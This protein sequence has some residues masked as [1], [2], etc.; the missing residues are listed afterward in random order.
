MGRPRI[1]Y[2]CSQER[3]Q[4]QQPLPTF[5]DPTYSTSSDDRQITENYT[6]D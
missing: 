4:Q 5:H 2:G 3:E 6:V 1:E